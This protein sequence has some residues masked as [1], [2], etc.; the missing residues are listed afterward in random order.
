[1]RHR[2]LSYLFLF[3]LVGAVAL[4]GCKQGGN[5][6]ASNQATPQTQTTAPQASQQTG[7]MPG[8]QQAPPAEQPAA[9]ESANAPSGYEAQQGAASAPA[10]ATI[11]LPAGTRLRVSLNSEL[12]SAIS[13][14]GEHFTGRIADDVVSGGMVVIP[15][16][17]RVDGTVTD[18]KPMGHFKGGARLAVRLEQ[19]QLNAANFPLSTSTVERFLPGKGKRTAKFVGGGGGL[20]A[21]IGGIAGGGKGAAIGAVAGAGAGAAGAATTGNK[22][23]VLPA[24]TVLIFRLERRLVVNG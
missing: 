5:Q 23:I 6:Q 21:L 18:A 16:G 11:E 24:G 12:G 7:T 22:Q 14:P 2:I 1:M 9:P 15:R 20:G 17:T 19:I 4:S 13:E 3:T 10:P 8:V